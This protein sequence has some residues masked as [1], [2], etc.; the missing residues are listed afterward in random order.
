MPKRV[1]R[2]S[3]VL[4]VNPD[5]A[6]LAAFWIACSLGIGTAASV[7]AALAGR[8]AALVPGAWPALGLGA[9]VAIGFA[10]PGVLRPRIAERPYRAW[11][12]L[13][14]LYARG[15]RLAITW[16]SY[17]A[18]FLPARSDGRELGLQR[19]GAGDSIWVPTTPCGTGTEEGIGGFAGWSLRS[20]RFWALS[21][22]PYLVLVSLLDTRR[23]GDSGSPSREIYTL[24]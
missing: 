13:A 23:H 1:K 9:V 19:P 16:I 8:G 22:V 20:G 4:P 6:A 21:L 3:P 11:A 5:R 15:A 12:R 10:L 17:H 14:L 24:Y 7:V 2:L 18:I